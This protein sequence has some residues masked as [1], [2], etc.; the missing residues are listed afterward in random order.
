MPSDAYQRFLA[1]QRIDQEKWHDGEP[2]DLAA[3]ADATPEERAAVERTVLSLDN[4]DWRDL[5]LLAALDTDATRDRLVRLTTDARTIDIR[6]R[7]AEHLA[8]KGLLPHIDQLLADYLLRVDGA[9][10]TLA[11]R[12]AEKYPTDAVKRSLLLCARRHPDLG[13]HAAALAHYLAGRASSNFDWS[14]RPLYLR[15]RSDNDPAD[16]ERAFAELC[17]DV[18][19]DAATVA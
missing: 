18:G 4:Y 8:D 7:A 16:R 15:F 9:T 10:Q 2:Y 17:A 12:L 13:V 19:V 14:R 1:S 6:L 5:D 3:L 11:L